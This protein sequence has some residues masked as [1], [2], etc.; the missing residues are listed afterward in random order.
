M[1]A[2]QQLVENIGV[3]AVDDEHGN[4]GRKGN[5]GGG[6]LR[7]H[8][9]GTALR[10]GAAGGGKQVVRQ[11]IHAADQAGVGKAAGVAV[12]ETVY[13]RKVVQ[14]VCSADLGDVGREN[15]VAAEFGQLVSGDGVVL[16]DD[17]HAPHIEE[18]LKGVTGE[19]AAVGVIQHVAGKKDLCDGMSVEGE[20]LVIKAHQLTLANGGHSLL[21][22]NG[23]GAG[24]AGLGH[25][26]AHGSGGHKDD[27][28]ACVLKVRQHS[29][30]GADAAN[31][32]GSRGVGKGGG[33][34]LD[35]DTVT[36][37]Q[38]AH[39][40]FTLSQKIYRFPLFFAA[41]LYY[42][43]RE[44][45]VTFILYSE[46]R[47]I[48][49]TFCIFRRVFLIFLKSLPGEGR[50]YMKQKYTLSIADL[51]ISVVA[52]ATPAEVEKVRGVLDRKMREIYLKSRCPKTEAAL[53]C[54][55]D[56]VSDRMSQQEALESLEERCEKYATVLDSLK[57]RTAEQEEEIERLV[58]EN[59]LL[60][61]LLTQQRGEAIE[62]P[63]SPD[64]ISPTEFLAKVADAQNS[65]EEAQPRGL[66]V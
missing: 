2:I 51:Q 38:H 33:A 23:G 9:A 25:A 62:A 6:E 55:L 22:F 40:K 28:L 35:H 48:S 19:G 42:N 50:R 41:I 1:L 18:R 36:V 34:N 61:S 32:E 8:T 12:V 4:T 56:A 13:V 39:K 26:G 46:T 11:V 47:L 60:R 49:S 45:G 21:P 16:V 24:R 15:I 5:R 64:P 44:I 66:Y 10:A 52:D 53:L 65:T 27:L 20:E 43:K 58:A 57:E 29:D 54:A 63:I 17:G 31:M 37:F 3:L 7:L 30:K 59:A 14:D